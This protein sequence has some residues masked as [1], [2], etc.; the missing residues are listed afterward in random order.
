[1]R[2]A[3]IIVVLALSLAGC[4]SP[5]SIS[6]GIPG[7]PTASI[8]IAQAVFGVGT[9]TF[10]SG[11]D[12]RET[13]INSILPDGSMAQIN[14]QPGED[15]RHRDVYATN[16]DGLYWISSDGVDAAGNL[17]GSQHGTNVYLTAPLTLASGATWTRTGKGTYE[18][19]QCSNGVCNYTYKGG[20]FTDTN[21]WTFQG[22]VLTRIESYDDDDPAKAP[23]D[24]VNTYNAT[25]PMSIGTVPRC[26]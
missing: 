3:P 19:G 16:A 24:L 20:S 5:A 15:P 11:K 7:T 6:Q 18:W 22:G 8:N 1:M 4:G 23:F 13:F 12:L 9:F 26:K 17:V 14:W 2:H 10:C 21:T 25:G